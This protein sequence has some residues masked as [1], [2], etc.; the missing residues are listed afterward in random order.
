MEGTG[1]RTPVFRGDPNEGVVI[2]TSLAQRAR[3]ALGV[4]A[5][6]AAALVTLSAAPAVAA[7]RE[8]PDSSWGT[9]GRV[10]DIARV[11]GRIY[12]AGSFTAVRSPTGKTVARNHLAAL[13][14]VSGAVVG[15]WRA[16]TNGTV[17]DL[18]SSANGSTIYAG[19]AFS[20]VNGVGH[21]GLVAVSAASGDVRSAFRA[22]TNNTVWA[23]A[24]SGSRLFAGG[25]FT[26]VRAGGGSF[27][28]KHLAA[29]DSSSGAIAATWRPSTNATVKALEL[30]SDQTKLYAGGSF[31]TASG[32]P[33]RFLA[34]FGPSAGALNPTWRPPLGDIRPCGNG[35]VMDLDATSGLVYAAVGGR[36]GGNRAVALNATT[37]ALRWQ[38]LGDGD[39]QAISYAR[40]RVYIGGHFI[41]IANINRPKF[42]TV[43][44]SNGAVKKD[45]TPT[46]NGKMGIWAITALPDGSRLYIGG[47]FTRVSGTNR[48][49]FAQFRNG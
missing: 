17:Y 13:D 27:S 6:I 43:D 8:V 47:D 36:Q 14:A 29:V 49:H 34:A 19:G 45:F 16:N 24:R 15:G 12:L 5:L 21:R 18:A 42:L 23:L 41:K 11:G 39:V 25:S 20:A 2:I 48:Y 26:S 9:N 35:C 40:E 28:R 7:L 1:E 22:T 3:P 38:K 32:Q 33:R 31:T 46:M 10:H 4:A 30:S 37:G 44:A